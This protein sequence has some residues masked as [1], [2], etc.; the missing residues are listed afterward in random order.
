LITIP[1][2][3]RHLIPAEPVEGAGA[4]LVMEADPEGVSRATQHQ[5]VG[6]G[7]LEP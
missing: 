7:L 6:E 3:V 5:A 4:G 1:V 2:G